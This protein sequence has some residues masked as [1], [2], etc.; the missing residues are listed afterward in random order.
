M[1]S[2]TGALSILMPLHLRMG[3]LMGNESWHVLKM[4]AKWEISGVSVYQD[5]GRSEHQQNIQL[6]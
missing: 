4:L 2:V 1:L 6:L 3:D 5:M